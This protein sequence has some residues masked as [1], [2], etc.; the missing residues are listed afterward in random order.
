[1]THKTLRLCLLSKEP[2]FIQHIIY[3]KYCFFYNPVESSSW[4]HD[5]ICLA[6]L[7]GP[8]QPKINLCCVLNSLYVVKKKMNLVLTNIYVGY[9]ENNNGKISYL[10]VVYKKTNNKQW[11]WGYLARWRR[12]QHPTF[13][14]AK[15]TNCFICRHRFCCDFTGSWSHT[16]K[17]VHGG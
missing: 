16:D 12:K 10:A 5:D 1:M 14:R 4:E 8:K 7:S 15:N 17:D 3:T 13:C 2:S 11:D 9:G 6:H